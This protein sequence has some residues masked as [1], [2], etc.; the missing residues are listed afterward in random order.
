MHKRART[1]GLTGG[2]VVS[3]DVTLCLDYG[4]TLGRRRLRDQVR[5]TAPEGSFG[6]RGD[7]GAVL[8][9]EDNQV[10]GLH[11]AGTVGGASGFANPIERVLAELDVTIA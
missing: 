4:A 3:T 11:C 1:T 8:L 7:S 6:D 2:I 10:V 9:D 5:V